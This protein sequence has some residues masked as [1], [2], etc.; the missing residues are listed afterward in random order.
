MLISIDT[1]RADRLGSYGYER[2]TSPFLDELAGGGARFTQAVVAAHGT[3]PSHASILT[4]LPQEVHRVAYADPAVAA[5]PEDVT[6]LQEYLRGEGYVTLAVTGGGNVGRRLGFDRGFDRFS[7]RARKV[8][9]GVR[10]M[11]GMIRS[12][13][14]SGKPIFAFFH[15]YQVHS[16]YLPPES[17]RG[18][19]G[20]YD[21]TFVPTSE[22]LLAIAREPRAHLS[23]EDLAHVEAL[24]DAGI[25]YTD[26]TLRDFF[27]QLKDLGF[28]D[29][30][31][32]AVTSDH[33]EE[34]EE[35]GGLLHR[36]LLY[37]ELLRVPLIFQGR[38]IPSG[39]VDERR[40]TSLD[41]APTLLGCAGLEIPP[42]M[43]GRDLFCGAGSGN[44]GDGGDDLAVSQYGARS[45]S[46]RTAEWK[47]VESQDSGVELY[48]LPSDP[49]ER[50]NVAAGHR[51]V[52][53]RFRSYLRKWRQREAP[54]ARTPP[55]RVDF[56]A[57]EKE[58]L[59]SLG[60]LAD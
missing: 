42:E 25:R 45:Y 5:L 14:E 23:E 17:Y 2:D 9:G 1:L 41:V 28:L 57:E 51:D 37:D 8:R 27:A 20:K 10:R 24:Y 55:D 39:S 12:H 50:R 15:T 11:V 43:Q 60:Y 58:H 7:Q 44:G 16:P 38:G 33:G 35:H 56:T 21:S 18:I 32:L 47:Y 59:R 22:N 4:S 52:V 46:I 26:D 6:L 36:G 3:A 54:L 48:H 53:A 19:F 29:D 49:G 13:L 31:V 30:V 34:F 40:V